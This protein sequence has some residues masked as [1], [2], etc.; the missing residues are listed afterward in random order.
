L[1]LT[2]GE[3]VIDAYAG[4]G[5]FAALLAPR[6][7]EVV[8]I[9]ESPSAIVD[10]RIN[11]AA[12]PNVRHIEGKVEDVLPAL[13]LRPDALLLDPPRQGCHPAAINAVIA[14]APTKLIYV[15]CD[16]ATLARDLRLLV[17]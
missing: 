1:A 12:L 11:T 17:D 7:A 13:D 9:E 3:V 8:A 10:A 6:A 16:P 5:T 2:G 15:S 4:V 14:M